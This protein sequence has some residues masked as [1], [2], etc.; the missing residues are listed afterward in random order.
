MQSPAANR[1]L[2]EDPSTEKIR[3]QIPLQGGFFVNRAMPFHLKGY[4]SL[5]G[6]T[7][8]ADLHVKKIRSIKIR[9]DQQQSEEEEE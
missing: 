4:S 9:R 3:P 1:S 5:N 2:V 8:G 6:Q 7:K